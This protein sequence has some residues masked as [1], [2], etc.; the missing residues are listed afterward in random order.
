[1]QNNIA[2]VHISEIHFYIVKSNNLSTIFGVLYKKY[3]KNNRKREPTFSV[4]QL[5]IFHST[6]PIGAFQWLVT[7]WIDMMHVSITFNLFRIYSRSVT[8]DNN[9]AN[10]LPKHAC[11]F[12]QRQL[13]GI[14]DFTYACVSLMILMRL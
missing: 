7:L 8:T 1:M 2:T 9:H 14:I 11:K 3:N 13:V 12:N 6:L 10:I 5:Q 4:E